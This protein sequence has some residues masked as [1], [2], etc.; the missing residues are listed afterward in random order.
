MR[1]EHVP[2][3]IEYGITSFIYTARRPFHPKRIS[4]LQEQSE[5][6]IPTVVRSK[7]FVWLATRHSDS[8]EWASAGNLYCIDAGSTW[9]AEIPREEWGDDME[10]PEEDF[11]NPITEEEYPYGDRRQEIVI[12]GIHMD[13]EQVKREF[14]ACLL[15]DEEFALGPEG[16]KQFEDPWPMWELE[17]EL[18]GEEEEEEDEQ[19]NH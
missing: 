12:I 18:E 1:G 4:I 3:T 11:I 17:V 15:T 16:W 19:E 7:G 8:G 14:D 13:K 2:E 9:F 10:A 6:R 5:E